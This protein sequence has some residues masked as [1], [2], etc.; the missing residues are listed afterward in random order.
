MDDE[1]KKEDVI[2]IKKST[3]YTTCGF[4]LAFL[5]FLLAILIGYAIWFLLWGPNFMKLA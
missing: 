3:I 4:I 5:I 1:H 2:T